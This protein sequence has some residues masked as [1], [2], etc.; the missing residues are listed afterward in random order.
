MLKFGFFK[1]FFQLQYG[2]EISKD[3]TND[4]FIV[5]YNYLCKRYKL[6]K[7]M[8]GSENGEMWLVT[9]HILKVDPPRFADLLAMGNEEK[10]GIRDNF[11]ISS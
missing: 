2:G 5:S 11:Q 1:R 9:E 10:G 8:C 3:Y 6:S 4:Q 7:T